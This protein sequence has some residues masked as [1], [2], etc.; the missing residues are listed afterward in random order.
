[1]IDRLAGTLTDERL[2]AHL[3]ADETPENAE[4]VCSLYLADEHGRR[5]RRLTVAD[6]DSAPLATEGVW[7]ACADASL[8]SRGELVD[9]RGDVYRLQEA[10]VCT[11]APELRWHRHPP[12]A[13]Q[14]HGQ[15]VTVRQAI[16]NLE[17]YEPVRA[18]TAEALATPSRNSGVSASALRAELDHM[19]TSDVLLN[20]GLR[21]AVLAAVK[22]RGLTMSEIASRCGR[23]K[24]SDNGSPSGESVW[25][26]RRIGLRSESGKSA[27]TPWVHS[28]VLALIACQGLGLS[29]REVEL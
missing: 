21:E 25:L 23:V 1:V 7:T 12:C 24:V 27:P 9:G 18:I 6:L 2:I 28:D 4:I 16:G 15:V 11:S 20:R 26:G 13:E 22:E 3:A 14:D 8:T 19:Y 5:C 10:C 17:S 29:P